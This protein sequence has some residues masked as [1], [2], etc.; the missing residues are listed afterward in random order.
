ML[1]HMRRNLRNIRGSSFVTRDMVNSTTA[2]ILDRG[3]RL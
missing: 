3:K 2:Y 1:K